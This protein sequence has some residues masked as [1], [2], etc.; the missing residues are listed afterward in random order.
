MCLQEA[1]LL[2]VLC[3]L[4]SAVVL[5]FFS[6]VLLN[7]IDAVFLCYALDLD[8]QSVTKQEVHEVFSQVSSS[9]TQP[10]IIG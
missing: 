3:F 1:A 5:A 4:M 6:S 2:A 10:P 7:V 9:F 8:T